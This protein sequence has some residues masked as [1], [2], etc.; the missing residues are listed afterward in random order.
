MSLDSLSGSENCPVTQDICLDQLVP[1]FQPVMDITNQTVWR[2]ESLARMV[3]A[4]QRTFL[5]SQFLYLVERDGQ[6]SALT[7]TMFSRSAEYFR[8]L[9]MSW[10]INLNN[11]DIHNQYLARYITDYL[12]NYP[13]PGRV[14]VELPAQSVI[15]EPKA[16]HAFLSLCGNLQLQVYLDH[17]DTDRLLTD[18]LWRLPING[19]KVN[20]SML[21]QLAEQ[22]QLAKLQKQLM[23]NDICLI[24]EHVENQQQLAQLDSLGIVYAQGFHLSQPNA[25]VVSVQR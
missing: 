13:N 16:F 21:L 6:I 23:E 7:E 10:S 14:G 20:V 5:P 12:A 2:Y 3:T 15:S 9:N 22:Q 17:L 25:Q 8:H 4:D 19:I 11:S 1:F 18:G 24:A